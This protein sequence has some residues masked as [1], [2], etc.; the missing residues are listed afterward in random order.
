MTVVDP[1]GLMLVALRDIFPTVNSVSI[2]NSDVPLLTFEN[3]FMSQRRID[4]WYQGKQNINY[5]QLLLELLQLGST[6]L[7]IA[8]GIPKLNFSSDVL[9]YFFSFP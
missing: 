1:L 7:E 8:T 6:F 9:L 5:L 2:L 3:L 4:Y